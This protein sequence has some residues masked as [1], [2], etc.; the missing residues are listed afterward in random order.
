MDDFSQILSLATSNPW[1]FLVVS[2]MATLI[3]GIKWYI[4]RQQKKEQEVKDQQSMQ[5]QVGEA[6][7]D[8]VNQ[9]RDALNKLNQLDRL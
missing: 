1:L 2:F 5:K 8:Y 6:A 9:D 4:K 3:S 7:K